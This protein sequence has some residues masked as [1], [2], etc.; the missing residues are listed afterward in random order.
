MS[1]QY[2]SCFAQSVRSQRSFPLS[3]LSIYLCNA[4][5]DSLVSHYF[6]D[7]FSQLIT[8]RP[9]YWFIVSC[10]NW[11]IN[12]FVCF[13]LFVFLSFVHSFLDSFL[14]KTNC[15][16]NFYSIHFIWIYLL[17]SSCSFQSCMHRSI[18]SFIHSLKVSCLICSFILSDPPWHHSKGSGRSW[19]NPMSWIVTA[20]I[21]VA[22]HVAAAVKMGLPLQFQNGI[23]AWC[24]QS[25]PRAC[26]QIQ[27]NT[28]AALWS[29]STSDTV[30]TAFVNN[31]DIHCAAQ[32]GRRNVDTFRESGH[33]TASR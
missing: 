23:A 30:T 2:F 9:F 3:V 24:R 10:L 1:I 6:I 33:F 22:K 12:L 8:S 29:G 27:S 32:R 26:C 5:V 13:H 7:R 31:T 16:F 14:Q 21:R 4:C 18:H 28:W 15:Y 11:F 20:A 19:S 25:H 17:C